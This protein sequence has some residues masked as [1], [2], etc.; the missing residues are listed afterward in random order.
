VARI[1]IV[2]GGCRGRELAREM[3]AAEH[4]VRITTRSDHSCAVIESIGAECVHGTPDRL[5]TLRGALDG[6]TVAC[7]LLAGASGPPDTLRELHGPRL[8]AFVRQTIDSTVRAF[9]Y[10][11]GSDARPR[12]RA[13]L[14]RGER[15]ARELC[16]RNAIPLVVLSAGIAEREAWLDDAGAAL[17]RLLAG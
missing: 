2:G 3:I 4:A 17:R 15:I 16:A 5:A 12:E 10:E 6:V 1:L 7:W 9:V 14:E 8:D 11:R 13:M